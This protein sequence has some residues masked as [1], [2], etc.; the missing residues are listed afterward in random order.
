MIRCP[1]NQI[2]VNVNENMDES[3][4]SNGESVIWKDFEAPASVWTND[5]PDELPLTLSKHNIL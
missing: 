5:F 2:S 4:L 1:L 3:D